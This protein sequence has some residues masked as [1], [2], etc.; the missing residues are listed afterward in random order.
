MGRR[1]QQFVSRF[2][3]TV[4]QEIILLRVKCA[5]ILVEMETTRVGNVLL[6]GRNNIKKQMLDITICSR[7]AV[8]IS[9]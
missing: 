9:H 6:V 5:A 4:A 1:G 7:C 2:T 3:L 8:P